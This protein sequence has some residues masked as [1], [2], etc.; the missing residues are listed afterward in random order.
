MFSLL[1][2][3]QGGEYVVEFDDQGTDAR[4]VLAIQAIEL[5][6]ESLGPCTEFQRQELSLLCLNM[7]TR[8]LT[9]F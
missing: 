9:L 6:T 4:V 3:L 2:C 7:L 8:P 5:K 1:A